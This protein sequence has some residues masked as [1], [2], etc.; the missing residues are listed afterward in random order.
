M[1]TVDTRHGLA[2]DP[3]L[4]ARDLLLDEAAAGG[5]L[6]RLLG[7]DPGGCTLVRVKYRIGESLRATYRLGGGELHTVRAFRPGESAAAYRKAAGAGVRH[8]PELDAV[9]WR[10]PADRRLRG[11]AEVLSPAADL[12]ALAPGWAGSELV[13]YSPERAA[14]FRAVD[15]AG[16]AVGYA[17]AYAPGTVDVVE[18][19]DRY[20]RVA[21]VLAAGGIASPLPLGRS[22]DRTVLV[23]QP[24]LG[25]EWGQ[26]AG[27]ALA[28][29]MGRLGAAIA[30][31][32]A[33]GRPVAAGLPRF[34]RLAVRRVVHSAHLVAAARP[35]VSAAAARLADRLAGGPPAG[36]PT[37]PLHGDCHPKNALLAGDSIALIDLDQ[38]GAGPAAA[39]LGSLIGRLHADGDTGPLRTAFLAGYQAV[40]ALPPEGSL[41]WHTAA[42]L[43]AER[44]VRAVNRV[45]LPTLD[46][47]PD[48]LGAAED[49]LLNGVRP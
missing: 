1:L 6:G 43:V 31:L 18:R 40:R 32:H 23:L 36:G 22:A 45:H 25:V 7:R 14:T 49:V 29:A 12:A 33:A 5:H 28:A 9:W 19:A 30:T 38:A 13:E 27:P 41:R 3:A 47:L 37:V 39:D 26:L 2:P 48:L 11:L 21:A 8:D 42:A 17:K 34:G 46:R 15:A 24:M 16:A 35:D 4:P 20:A 10:F 44:A